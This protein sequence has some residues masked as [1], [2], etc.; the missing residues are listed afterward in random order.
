MIVANKKI[1]RS[2]KKIRERVGA[3]YQKYYLCTAIATIAQSV[4]H[5]IRNEKVPG[6]SPGRGSAKRFKKLEPL[7]L[8]L[9]PFRSGR[10][11][12]PGIACE[13]REKAVRRACCPSVT[14]SARPLYGY[15][16][17]LGQISFYT[18]GTSFSSLLVI[19]RVFFNKDQSSRLYFIYLYRTIECYGYF[20]YTTS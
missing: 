9:L 7:F 18:S 20:A 17:I 10:V 5:F 3:F 11:D 13:I 8:C 2:N 15:L 4:E 6:S 14:L 16:P 1:G 19:G 12:W